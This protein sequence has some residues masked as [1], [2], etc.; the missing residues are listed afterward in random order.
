M[1]DRG[2]SQRREEGVVVM[3]AE[4]GRQRKEGEKEGL[5][6]LSVDTKSLQNILHI[7]EEV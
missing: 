1:Q 7:F 6:L 3:V 4:K 5:P 2:A